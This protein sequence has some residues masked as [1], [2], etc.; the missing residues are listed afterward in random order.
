MSKSEIVKA[1]FD[2]VESINLEIAGTHLA[3]N[4]TMKGPLPDPI[5]KDL[6]LSM[7]QSSLDAFSGFR[8]NIQDMVEDGNRITFIAE[9]E[10]KHTSDLVYPGLPVFRATNK[11]FRM[12]KEG[13]EII[14]D[15]NKMVSLSTEQVE[16]AGLTGLLKQLGLEMP[17][18]AN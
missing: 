17:S 8:H 11:H 14:F 4:F 15:G 6:F 10:G 5:P 9:V 1:F 3:E 12:P 13:N 2:A 16:G 18:P 7:M